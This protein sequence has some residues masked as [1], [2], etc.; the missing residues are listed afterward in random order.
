MWSTALSLLLLAC[1]PVVSASPLYFD[2]CYWSTRDASADNDAGVS[3]SVTTS[4]SIV[5][6]SDTVLA[7]SD[8]TVSYPLLTISGVR[9]QVNT[10][11]STN[12]SYITGLAPTGLEHDNDNLIGVAWPTLPAFALPGG[13]SYYIDS[14]VT[15]PGTTDPTNLI[16]MYN[17]PPQE[18]GMEAE[19]AYAQSYLVY[20]PG[21]TSPPLLCPLPG[22]T[23]YQL[24]VI[25]VPTSV[26]DPSA[27]WSSCTIAD[28]RLVGPYTSSNQLTGSTENAY[29]V[30]GA[31]GQR[32]FT[33]ITGSYATHIVDITNNLLAD[34]VLYAQYPYVDFGG[35][36]FVH[37]APPLFANGVEWDD[38]DMYVLLR[39]LGSTPVEGDASDSAPYA[40][41]DVQYSLADG[42]SPLLQCD[43]GVLTEVWSFC[44]FST[45]APARLLPDG[46][47]TISWNVS[48]YG[49]LLSLPAMANGTFMAT[50]ISA[51]RTQFFFDGTV[52]T[53]VSLGTE[54]LFARLGSI[55]GGY[56]IFPV[57][58]DNFL[59]TSYPYLSDH[60]LLYVLDGAAQ[61]PDQPFPWPF[62]QL[63]GFPPVESGG[64]P[65]LDTEEA[66]VFSYFAFQRASV[67]EVG[68]GDTATS[69]EF[70]FYYSARSTD[71]SGTWSVS[72]VGTL[73]ALGPYYYPTTVKGVDTEVYFVYAASGQR[74]FISEQGE[75]CQNSIVGVSG[76]V[77]ADFVLYTD[78]SGLSFDAAGMVF[79]LDSIPLFPNGPASVPYIALRT[80]TAVSP[81]GVSETTLTELALQ[82]EANDTAGMTVADL[83]SPNTLSWTHRLSSAGSSYSASLSLEA[84][85]LPGDSLPTSTAAGYVVI[86]SF[87]SSVCGVLL[88]YGSEALVVS[89]YRKQRSAVWV[90]LTGTATGA[91]IWASMLAFLSST[92]VDCDACVLPMSVQF[93]LQIACL[94]LLPA[95][96]C[97]LLAFSFASWRYRFI[98]VHGA[99]ANQVRPM[100][101]SINATQTISW[102]ADGSA[103]FTGID[104]GQ[105]A[106]RSKDAPNPAVFSLTVEVRRARGCFTRCIAHFGL[107]WLVVSALCTAAIVLTRVI[108]L[109]SFA[110]DAEVQQTVWS[111]IISALIVWLLLCVVASISFH[112]T[113]YRA[114]VAPLLCG[115]LNIDY[116]MA[117]RTATVT[118]HPERLTS[119]ASNS[120]FSTRLTANTVVLVGGVVGIAGVVVILALKYRKMRVKQKLLTGRVTKAKTELGM[121]KQRLKEEAAHHSYTRSVFAELSVQMNAINAL[122]PFQSSSPDRSMQ[123]LIL[124]LSQKHEQQLHDCT[125]RQVAHNTLK[126]VV[127]GAHSKDAKSAQHPSMAAS[128][129]GNVKSPS[130]STRSSRAAEQ[131][132]LSQTSAGSTSVTLTEAPF[133]AVSKEWVSRTDREQDDFCLGL[134]EAWRQYQQPNSKRSTSDHGKVEPA[135]SVPPPPLPPPFDTFR[136]SLPLVLS[137]PVTLE[138]FK[139]EVH[140]AHCSENTAVYIQLQRWKLTPSRAVRSRMADYL[141]A[142][143][144]D[145]TAT[146]TI[147]IDSATRQKLLTRLGKSDTSLDLFVDVE[148]EVLMLLETNHWRQFTRSAAYELCTAVLLRNLNVVTALASSEHGASVGLNESSGHSRGSLQSHHSTTAALSQEETDT[149]GAVAEL[150]GMKVTD[151]DEDA[152]HLAQ[153]YPSE[154]ESG[155]RTATSMTT[156]R[157]MAAVALRAGLWSPSLKSGHRQPNG[158]EGTA[159]VGVVTEE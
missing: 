59:F 85:L 6:D 78:V 136:P 52:T 147:N 84:L 89:K 8:G 95:L 56:H 135:D 141:K 91:L 99:A 75:S 62:I 111:S 30:L 37:D 23:T 70:D 96:L 98:D 41:A 156:T 123:A 1:V 13:I 122:R 50:A 109:Y 58:N 153:R 158:G 64:P 65:F 139:D 113:R 11:G 125:L 104:S 7:A 12:V 129:S 4:G 126:E 83:A 133:G 28:L 81:A 108:L 120:L 159:L 21:Q 19:A 26:S 53:N 142:E 67:G 124:S 10:D 18:W 61:L 148:K 48:T 35:I 118:F 36:N 25:S 119:L 103:D 71:P 20:Q 143:F 73:S 87:I 38:A 114:T 2:F 101:T 15:L 121:A 117:A 144:I 130:Q 150:D 145:A 152:H 27:L 34:Q 112:G 68:C 55:Q 60:G 40:I 134:L 110:C 132:A 66:G 149:D 43:A 107:D 100:E 102:D 92:S 128:G 77:Q 51:T 151:M 140:A 86:G 106:E 14:N 115:A 154:T 80:T 57:D 47:W 93:S 127:E 46:S 45:S 131:S 44:H 116:Q 72:A 32:N 82:G 31:T 17:M 146:N 138:L 9:T 42:L 24:R 5:V 22:P 94:A 69:A 39:G 76:A 16:T 90:L 63:H 74:L 155:E 137:H 157:P 79:E 97:P 3:W 33:N 29:T 105:L 49:T 54:T 88:M